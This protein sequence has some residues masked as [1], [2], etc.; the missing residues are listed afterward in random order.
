L[1]FAENCG[2]ASAL[3]ERYPETSE[4]AGD[5]TDTHAEIAAGIIGQ[6]DATSDAAKAAVKW[7]REIIKVLST[8]SAEGI[9]D[10]TIEPMLHVESEIVLLDDEEHDFDTLATGH[11]DL[12]IET[13]T[14]LHVVDWKRSKWGNV[15]AA[16]RN[17]QLIS[18]GLAKANGRPFQVHLVFGDDADESG[19][20]QPRSSRVIMPEEHPALLAWIRGLATKSTEPCAGRHCSSCYVRQYCE[21]YRARM[22]SALAVLGTDETRG[23]ETSLTQDRAQALDERLDFAEKWVKWAKQVRHDYVL[24]GGLLLREGKRAHI[25]DMPGRETA[26]CA[27]LRADGLD[28][29]IKKGESF[30]KIS[31]R[32][33]KP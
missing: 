8:Y 32:K 21:A 6:K 33:Y 31:W 24:A 27:A 19:N 29:Y 25:I 17:A 13:H 28:K 4:L 5:G 3:A 16:D 2:H 9:P 11:P 7:V 1:A 10:V 26:D 18:Y 15:P 12:L 23:D 20:V 30:D 14:V 22:T